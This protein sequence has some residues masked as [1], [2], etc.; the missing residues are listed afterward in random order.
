LT[1]AWL[2]ALALPQA[3][4]PLT[5]EEAM[6]IAEQ[7]SFSIALQQSDIEKARQRVNEAAASLKPQV[8]ASGTY[9]RNDRET[10][11]SFGQGQTV[12][13]Q[14]ID[15]STIGGSVS[16]P[17][18]ISLRIRRGVNAARENERASR[19]TLDAVRSDIRLSVKNAYYAV[20]KA[21]AL[22]RVQQA[23][24]ESVNARLTQIRRQVEL[25]STARVELTRQET[26]RQQ[27]ITN[28]ESAQNNL[29][30]ALYS[31]NQALARPIET[32]VTVVSQLPSTT[33]AATEAELVQTAYAD[34]AELRALAATRRGLEQ[35]RKAQ[36][37]GDDPSLN[38]SVQYQRN[39]DP[40]GLT[41]QSEATAGVLSL[42]IPIFDGGATR[43]RV[44]QA[45]QDEAQLDIQIAQSRLG[46]SQEVRSARVS[47]ESARA[48]VRAAQEQ[49]RLANELLR[50]ADVRQQAGEGT[51]VERIDAQ[52][53]VTEA[54][55][56][57]VNARFDE[58]LAYAQLQRA[59]GREDLSAP[60]GNTK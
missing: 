50:I 43:A 19:A 47:L 2:W 25:G 13:I 39:L 30:Q 16:I 53:E 27:T 46:I 29:Q 57:L 6:R 42:S 34:R 21:Q 7:N 20:L 35:A 22:V 55:T 44:R 23:T 8:S 12:V 10:T 38:V 24:L 18:D 60:S 15:S 5:L 36:E 59:V 1:A 9:T 45:R 3:E 14:P 41:A 32:P 52:R 11:A 31:L 49:L 58:V 33:V 40:A 48:R 51:Y 26:L 56:N 17:I 4:P 37:A 54:E 28:L